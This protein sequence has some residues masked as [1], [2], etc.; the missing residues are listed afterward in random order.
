[1]E[2]KERVLVRLESREVKKIAL[3]VG[4]EEVTNQSE[5]D[6]KTGE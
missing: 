4:K 6:E 5:V 1:M 3:E 2:W